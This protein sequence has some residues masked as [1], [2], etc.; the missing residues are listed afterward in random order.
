MSLFPF[1]IGS[2]ESKGRSLDISMI[3]D[4]F[5]SVSVRLNRGAK[6][7]GG[8]KYNPFPFRIGSI[9]SKMVEGYTFESC[10][11]SVSVRL[12]RRGKSY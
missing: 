9:E 5:H 12:N 6:V 10:F 11:H 2:I 8:W 3:L 1:R 7:E 4:S